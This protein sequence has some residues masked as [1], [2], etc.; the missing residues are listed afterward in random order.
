MIKNRIIITL[1]LSS[2]IFGQTASEKPKKPFMNTNYISF[3][4]TLVI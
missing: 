3:L 4:G 2:I 1:I